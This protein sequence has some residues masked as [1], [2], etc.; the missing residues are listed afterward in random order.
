MRE[1]A[2]G[3]CFVTSLLTL[4]VVSPATL[5]AID[6]LASRDIVPPLRFERAQ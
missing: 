1:I 6:L 2:C 4:P 5:E 3:D